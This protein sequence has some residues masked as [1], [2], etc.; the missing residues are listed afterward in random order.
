MATPLPVN[1]L[2]RL[3]SVALLFCQVV[4]GSARAA[5]PIVAN[6]N[7]LT[8]ALQL[9][10][11]DMARQILARNPAL[12]STPPTTFPVPDPGISGES[13]RT[14]LSLVAGLVET[15]LVKAPC[16]SQNILQ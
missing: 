11:T 7:S 6:Y 14:A 4:A 1:R 12:A 15:N 9:R 2:V 5:T 8:D 13:V 3:W 10:Q 16:C